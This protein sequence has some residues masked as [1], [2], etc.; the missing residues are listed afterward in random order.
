MYED[1]NQRDDPVRLEVLED[2][3]R[4]NGLCHSGC[5]DRGNDVGEDVVLETFL[6]ECFCETDLCEFGSCDALADDRG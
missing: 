4:H 6:C 5:G 1:C 3:G 2:I